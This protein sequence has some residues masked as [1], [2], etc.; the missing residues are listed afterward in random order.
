[1]K[2]KEKVFD[3]TTY[4]NSNIMDIIKDLSKR[5]KSRKFDFNLKLSSYGIKTFKEYFE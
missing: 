5:R 4:L 1:M 3:E 2:N